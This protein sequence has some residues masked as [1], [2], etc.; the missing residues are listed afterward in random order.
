MSKDIKK[1]SLTPKDIEVNTLV[2]PSDLEPVQASE[3]SAE[4]T[5][6][7]LE[8]AVMLINPDHDSM[9]SRG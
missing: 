1:N 4:V 2:V 5:W 7:E 6:Q 8:D 9:E 3:K